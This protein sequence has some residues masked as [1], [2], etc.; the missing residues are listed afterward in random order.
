MAT[1]TIRNLDDD[2]KQRLRVRA[3]QHGHSM[4]EEVRTILQA[5]VEQDREAKPGGLATR[6]LDLFKD[7]D[8]T[9]FELPE[10][11]PMPE[12]ISFDE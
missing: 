12:P 1:L 5:S 11:T 8:T 4:E 3:A 10:R 7:I 2:V 6:L 9:G